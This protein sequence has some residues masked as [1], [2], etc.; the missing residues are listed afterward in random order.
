MVAFSYPPPRDATGTVFSTGTALTCSP[1]CS[2]DR[3]GAVTGDGWCGYAVNANETHETARWECYY[4]GTSP[5]R[6]RQDDKK[7]KRKPYDHSMFSSRKTF[8][9]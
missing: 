8:H 1:A 2:P 6:P 4:N 5:D 3:G 9:R 7:K